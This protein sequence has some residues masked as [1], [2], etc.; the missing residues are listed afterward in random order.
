MSATVRDKNWT[1]ACAKLKNS[2]CNNCK[3]IH[4]KGLTIPGIFPVKNFHI[5]AQAMH[6]YYM[7][8]SI[9]CHGK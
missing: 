6:Y 5:L 9:L 1:E 3:F 4:V 8:M 7:L 2:R